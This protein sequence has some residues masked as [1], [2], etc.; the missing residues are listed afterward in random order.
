MVTPDNRLIAGYRRLL[1]CQRL[2]WTEVPVRVVRLTEIVRGECAENTFRK[3]FTPS[4]A[5]A[6]AAALRPLET[7]AAKQRQ[8]AAGPKAGKGR[9][10]SGSGKLPEAVGQVRDRV[11]AHVGM[12]GRTLEKATDVVEAA[13]DDPERFAP[14][15]AQM[16]RTGKVGGVHKRL[17]RL[18]QARALATEPPPLP[19]G[20]FRVLVIDPPWPYE[21]RTDDPTQ[22][23][24]CPYVAMSLDE[25]RALPVESLAADDAV[26]W[27]WTP[28]T[29]LPDAFSV[30]SAWGFD[31]KVPLTWV[32]PHFGVGEWLRGQTEHCLFAVRG[33]PAVL[34]ESEGTA[35]GAETTGH[36][37]KPEAFFE[38]VERMCPG[39]KLE[40]FA[41]ARRPGWTTWGL[42]VAVVA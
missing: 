1:A 36:S 15:V 5:V 24:T 22:R 20:P 25:I 40:L 12:S 42:E 38:K 6:M 26:L 2:G 10:R 7:K 23:G 34:G 28:N 19:T 35:L 17:Q 8:A 31:Y 3:D 18:K 21:K 11:A 32:K 29:F 30:V 16:D 37:R 4:E 41:R 13:N 14:L 27:L 39:S 9:K 33:H